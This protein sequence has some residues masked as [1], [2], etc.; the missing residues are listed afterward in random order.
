[1][2]V[3]DEPQTAIERET[4]GRV[5]DARYHQSHLRRIKRRFT[6]RCFEQSLTIIRMGPRR[7]ADHSTIDVVVTGDATAAR[8]LPSLKR[9]L[10]EP[11]PVI[12]FSP[13]GAHL[14]VHVH[15]VSYLHRW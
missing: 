8:E 5:V 11:D 3:G 10:R 13:G 14:P 1:M 15:R 4:N 9:R 6:T 2:R 12:Y 7:R